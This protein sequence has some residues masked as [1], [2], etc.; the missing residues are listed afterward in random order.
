MKQAAKSLGNLSLRDDIDDNETILTKCWGN[1][2]QTNQTG[3]R[4][5]TAK[6]IRIR[7]RTGK[8]IKTT[9]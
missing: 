5:G 3:K 7:T 8:V 2:Y 1:Y 6:D 9:K 4:P